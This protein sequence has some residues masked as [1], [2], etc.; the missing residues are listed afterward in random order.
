M[1]CRFDMRRV[2]IPLTPDETQSFQYRCEKCA[3]WHWVIPELEADG[4][5]PDGPA[6][7][8]AI[9]DTLDRWYLSTAG[10]SWREAVANGEAVYHDEPDWRP[11][12]VRKGGGI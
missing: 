7:L 5:A 11:Q 2:D 6:A 12:P 10:I 1:N 4:T 9:K 3:Q 8:E